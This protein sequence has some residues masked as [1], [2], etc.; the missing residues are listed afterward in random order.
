[1]A[2]ENIGAVSVLIGGDYSPLIAAFGQAQSVAQKAGA[3][4]ANAF[5]AGAGAAPGIVD[6]FGRS[7]ASAGSAS[8]TAAPQVGALSN[9]TASLAANANAAA[10]ALVRQAAAAHA[11]VTEIQAT[12][13]ALRVL[14]GS[15]GIRAA[16]RLLTMIPGL[17]A[18]LQAAFPVIGAIALLEVVGRMVGKAYELYQ[19]WTEVGIATQFAKDAAEDYAK[20][21]DKIKEKVAQIDLKRF[22]Q[23]FGGPEGDANEATALQ[24]Q[25]NQKQNAANALKGEIVRQQQI[26]DSA[27]AS[28]HAIYSQPGGGG[29]TGQ[30]RLTQLSRDAEAAHANVD[31]LRA[32]IGQ[33]ENEAFALRK[34]SADKGQS[35][36]TG[37]KKESDQGSEAVAA[38]HTAQLQAQDSAAQRNATSARQLVEIR[39]AAAKQGAQIE[40]DA[41]ESSEARLIANALAEVRIEKQKQDQL[42]AIAASEAEVRAR[43]AQS[44]GASES[45]G[46]DANQRGAIAARVTEQVAGIQDAYSKVLSE[47]QAV[48]EASR[49]KVAGDIAN[50]QRTLIAETTK[51]LDELQARLKE[52]QAQIDEANARANEAAAKSAGEVG[53]LAIEAQKLKL[54][55]AYGLAIAHNGQQQVA[56]QQQLAEIDAAARQSKIE[57]LKNAQGAVP[58]DGSPEAIKENQRLQDEIDK[59]QAEA[60]NADIQ[61]NTKILELKQQQLLSVQLQQD[62]LRA[63]SAVPGAIGGGIAAGVFQHGKNT[64][65]GDEIAKSLRGIGQQLFGQVIGQLITK[66]AIQAAVQAG[67]ITVTSANTAATATNASVTGIHAGVMLTHAGVMIA[68]IAATVAHTIATIAQTIATNLNTLWLAIKAVFGFADGGSPPVGIA[69][70]VGE[71][72]PELFVPRQAGVVIPNHMIKGYADGG[73]LSHMP[74]AGGSRSSVMHTSVFSGDMHFHAHGVSPQQHAQMMIREVPKALKSR[75]A[76]WSPYS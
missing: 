2:T 16:E 22:R 32:S 49:Q 44:I 46:K 20:S 18:A 61:A 29:I 57:G 64:G 12:S 35:S 47:A 48:T 34:E 23:T 51:G 15:G 25:A 40:N 19:N 36:L 55:Q 71:R 6:Q 28:I 66:M 56:Y 54:E 52:R 11:G 59:A 72:G 76:G 33:L 45:V 70:L 17:G 8:A 58:K 39:A 7:V 43:L 14:E 69:S 37:Q 67:L 5:N 3:N 50:W 26:L 60:N 41:L 30:S 4:V 1:M 74:S 38:A 10:N 62:L 31:A 65:I 75:G 63:A 24:D 68:H 73:G 21:V 53:G 27:N 42:V 13:G 9:Q